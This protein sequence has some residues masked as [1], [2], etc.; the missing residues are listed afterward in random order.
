[1]GSV[2]KGL[3]IYLFIY[4][5]TIIRKKGHTCS[6]LVFCHCIHKVQSTPFIADGFGPRV[7]VLNSESP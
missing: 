2:N 1:M 6:N 5:R 7:S 3:F 4:Y